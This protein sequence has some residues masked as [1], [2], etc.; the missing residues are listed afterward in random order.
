[1][2]SK[3]IT[4]SYFS[5]NISI[6]LFQIKSGRSRD[7]QLILC[8]KNENSHGLLIRRVPHLK[9]YSV[10]LPLIFHNEKKN[11]KNICSAWDI[12]KSYCFKEADPPPQKS[13]EPG[14]THGHW[15]VDACVDACVASIET[16]HASTHAFIDFHSKHTWNKIYEEI[17][18]HIYKFIKFPGYF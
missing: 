4:G 5:S 8:H 15:C 9:F 1:M 18:F 11:W 13:A 14:T 12:T 3:S 7:P 17:T 6:E 10:W 16:T 2:L